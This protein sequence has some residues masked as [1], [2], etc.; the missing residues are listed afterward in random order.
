[1]KIKVKH[2]AQVF[3]EEIKAL[4]E[5]KIE[6]KCKDFINLLVKY[7][8]ISKLDQIVEVFETLWNKETKTVVA[9]IITSRKIDKEMLDNIRE[10]IKSESS[11]EQI[12]IK[13][14]INKNILGGFVARFN[15]TILD[16][17]LLNRLKQL[18]N[19]LR[20]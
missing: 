8:D 6:E 17:S 14:K 9:N 16:A 5:D 15:N 3:Y 12:L 10:Y 7:N 13:Q 18:R 2:Y 19:S 4:P 20:N 11:A 1:M